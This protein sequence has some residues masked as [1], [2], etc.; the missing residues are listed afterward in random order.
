MRGTSYFNMV[1]IIIGRG[2]YLDYS[3]FIVMYFTIIIKVMIHLLGLS[4]I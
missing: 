4:Y 2:S 3:D 1:M